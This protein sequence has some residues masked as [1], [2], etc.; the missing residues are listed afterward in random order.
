MARSTKRNHHAHNLNHFFQRN[1]MTTPMTGLQTALNSKIVA[2]YIKLVVD[3]DNGAR[4]C[5]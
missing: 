1:S 4:R 2:R 5:D 3:E